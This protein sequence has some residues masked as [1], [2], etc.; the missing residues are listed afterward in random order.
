MSKLILIDGN[1][2]LH[3]AYHALP[4]LTSKKGEPI[5][6]V[7]GFISMLLRVVQDLKPTHITVA[8]DTAKP[9]FRHVAYVGYQAQRPRVDSELGSQFK[10][11]KEVLESFGIPT[12]AAPGFEADDVIGTLAFQALTINHQPLEIIIVT[13]DRD[14]LQLVDEKTKVYMPIKGLTDAKLFGKDEVVE[15]LGVN[16]EQ[17]VDYKALVGDQSDNYSG[18]SG[19]G[20]KTTISLIEKYGTLEEIYKHLGDLP[21]K[22]GKNLA[23]GAENAGLSKKLA[24]VVCD[25]PVTLDFEKAGKWKID[26]KKAL[27][28]FAKLGFKTLTKRI[29]NVGGQID[30][31]KQMSLI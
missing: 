10:I 16:P 18:V 26:S 9:T 22:L 28:L 14:L 3:R 12:F 17:V 24:T 20:P 30:K 27:T 8:F 29:K 4:P 2:I 13:G 31:E 23:Q 15:R 5:G 6:A 19:V 7:Y 1:A 21:E 25:V 11:A